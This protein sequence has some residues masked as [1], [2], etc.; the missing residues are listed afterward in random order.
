MKARTK[1]KKE[2]IYWNKKQYN[3]NFGKNYDKTHVLD[4]NNYIF[5]EIKK[6]I[7]FIK[8]KFKSKKK[9]K[10]LDIGCGTGKLTLFF[11]KFFPNAKFYA[12]DVSKVML[13]NLENKIPKSKKVDIKFIC[14]DVTNYLKKTNIKFDMIIASGAYHHFFDYLKVTD[15]VTK[16]LNEKGII[17]ISNESKNRNKINF[18]KKY[19]LDILRIQDRQVYQIRKERKVSFINIAY[20][21]YSFFNFLTPI[22]LKLKSRDKAYYYSEVQGQGLNLNKMLIL[23]KKRDFKIILKNGPDFRNRFFYH[24]ANNLNINDHFRLIGEKK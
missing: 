21:I 1:N 3:G 20:F 16:K 13:K 17:Y 12:L 10:I 8:S 5:D 7:N 18:F 19:F 6:D 4:F 2:A 22:L 11:M 9:L 15:L 23:L 24:I 14:S